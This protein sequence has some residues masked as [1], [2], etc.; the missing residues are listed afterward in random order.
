MGKKSKYATDADDHSDAFISKVVGNVSYKPSGATPAEQLQEERSS[1]WTSDIYYRLES[2][3]SGSGKRSCLSVFVLAI[4]IFITFL[5]AGLVVL[6]VLQ[7]HHDVLPLCPGCRSLS[8]GLFIAGG[9]VVVIGVVGI[10]AAATRRK[11]FAVPFAF[12]IALLGVAFMALGVGAVV[13]SA[14][15]GSINL[16]SVWESSVA[17]DPSL[18]CTLQHQLQCSGFSQGCCRAT[19]TA[20]RNATSSMSDARVADPRHHYQSLLV[21]DV[22]N[23]NTYCYYVYPNGTTVNANNTVVTW[24][25]RDCAPA[26][27]V[28]NAAYVTT[29]SDALQAQIKKYLIPIAA[30]GIGLGLIFLV[31]GGQAICM[32]RKK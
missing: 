22:I 25:V 19:G 8:T 28:E 14:A 12:L 5:G 2:G 4:S 30:V 18:I 24:P 23:N 21:G 29:C 32:T 10:L 13:Y 3:D 15:V 1:T 17:I 6:G 26:C 11:A 31:L 9:I 27:V 20:N 7:Q 16:Q